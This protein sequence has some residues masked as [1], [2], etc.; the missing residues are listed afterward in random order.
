[1]IVLKV[2]LYILYAF[3]AAVLLW[4]FASI[5]YS[6]PI[7]S[8]TY[9]KHHGFGRLLAYITCW[10]AFFFTRSHVKVIGKEK[11]PK[12]TRFVFVAN[13]ISRFDPMVI[14]YKFPS[15]RMSFISKPSNFKIPFFGKIIRKICFLEINREDPRKALDT[16]SDAVDI[17]KAGEAS[18]GFYPEG[19]RSKDGKLGKFHNFMFRIPNQAEVPVVVCVTRGTEDVAKRFPFPG[20][21]RIE[22]KVLDVLDVEFV[23]SHRPVE[24]G[25]RV[26][27]LIREELGQ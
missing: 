17:L 24:I 7:K 19:T 21:A 26:E 5:V 27:A 10:G 13:H 15:S 8:K 20:G 2:L 25:E 22:I 14:M 11:L 3:L 18:I 9:K 6:L 1:M 12:D 16:I 4:L 23:K